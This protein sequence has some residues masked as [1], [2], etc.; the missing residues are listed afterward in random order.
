LEV[1]NGW[2]ITLEVKNEVNGESSIMLIN[3]DYVPIKHNFCLEAFHRVKNCLTLVKA[4][5]GAKKIN[6]QGGVD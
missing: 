3:Y 5:M 6:E 4:K 1:G 2:E